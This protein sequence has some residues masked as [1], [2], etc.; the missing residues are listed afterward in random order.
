MDEMDGIQTGH[1]PR[2]HAAVARL[3]EKAGG[4]IYRS[5]GKRKCNFKSKR[6]PKWEFGNQPEIC[7][8]ARMGIWEP[9]RMGI[10]EPAE[11]ISNSKRICHSNTYQLVAVFYLNFLIFAKANRDTIVNP[12]SSQSPRKR[13]KC[14]LSV[15]SRWQQPHLSSSPPVNASSSSLLS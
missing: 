11:L 15:L 5:D 7:E 3:K 1:T 4:Y 10:W 14:S 6:V 9:A 12:T 8:P 13:L 2:C